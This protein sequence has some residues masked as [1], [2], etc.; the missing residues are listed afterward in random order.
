[1]ASGEIYAT[2]KAKRILFP[3]NKMFEKFLNKTLLAICVS[4]FIIFAPVLLF[5]VSGYKYDPE[6]QKLIKTGGLFLSFWP[7]S[8]NIY[9]DGVLKKKHYH[10]DIL[11]GLRWVFQ[12]ENLLPGNHKIKISLD[13]YG[14]WEKEIKIDESKVATIEN[15]LLLPK[16]AESKQLTAFKDSSLKNLAL[17]PDEKKLVFLSYSDAGN[18]NKSPKIPELNIFNLETEKTEILIK[19][20]SLKFLLKL[21]TGSGDITI[22]KI[23]WSPDESKILFRIFNSKDFSV[24]WAVTDMALKQTKILE[25][26]TAK[27]NSGGTNG[28]MV[29]PL[30]VNENKL[31]FLN[32]NSLFL[33]DL[34]NEKLPPASLIADN[35]T[36]YLL[37]ENDVYFTQKNTLYKATLADLA[38]KYPRT[39]ALSN[40]L[41]AKPT[42]EIAK[43]IISQNNDIFVLDSK[44]TLYYLNSKN[45]FEPLNDNVANAEM[46]PNN[47]ILA[48]STPYEIWA[49]YLKNNTAMKLNKNAKELIVRYNSAIPEFDWLEDSAHLIFLID[50]QIKISELDSRDYRQTLNLAVD[51][52]INEFVHKYEKDSIYFIG[53]DNNIY[54][55]E[56]KKR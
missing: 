10:L 40:N 43:I 3:S 38:S 9:I 12:E 45:V 49:Y 7:D 17:S 20:D 15:I 26:I 1:M 34:K 32:N 55:T 52:N 31:L 28:D 53:Q 16:K 41:T 33:K 29:N 4:I 51:T 22:D 48:F 36:S 27:T 42:S 8:A 50:N 19:K 11:T 18:Q 13:G 14:D 6:Q 46:S 35:V 47:E 56:L 23:I 21:K 54:L 24:N 39:T 44:N 2:I 5:Y 30:W 37:K 25:K